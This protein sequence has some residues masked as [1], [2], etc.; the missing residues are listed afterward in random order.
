M[1]EGHGFYNGTNT[2]AVVGELNMENLV[3]STIVQKMNR[4][5]LKFLYNKKD[6]SNFALVF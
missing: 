4:G 5:A 1:A 2:E 3:D 6:V